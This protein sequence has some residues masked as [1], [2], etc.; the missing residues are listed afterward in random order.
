MRTGHDDQVADSDSQKPT[1]QVGREPRPWT[2]VWG[3]IL[4]LV[5]V[6][7]IVCALVV[8]NRR[9]SG[10]SPFEQL[11]FSVLTLALSTGG[12]VLMAEHYARRQGIREYQQLAKPALRRV[13]EL[14]GGIDVIKEYLR[15]RRGVLAT[16]QG[17]AL[18][19]VQEWLDGALALLELHVG[20]LR[21]SVADWQELL[22]SE[23]QRV[24]SLM[25]AKA[26][27]EAQLASLQAQLAARTA[28]LAAP[29]EKDVNAELRTRA[30][31]AA[32]QELIAGLK[33]EQTNLTYDAY[34]PVA[35]VYTRKSWRPT[36]VSQIVAR[37]HN[38]APSVV[39]A[40]LAQMDFKSMSQMD[41]LIAQL[42]NTPASE[43]DALIA[44]LN[45]KPARD[46]PND[47]QA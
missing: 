26:Q 10:L 16:E 31:I 38:P 8:S 25:E 19:V 40:V 7:V 4:V 12:S 44:Q 33:V 47:G 37:L 42:N 43:I 22:P 36:D 13:L 18:E 20:Q 46:T 28:N 11:L 24:Q 45:H 23:Y 9:E 21:A 35:K 30:E 6:S 3:L 27:L 5:G 15:D 2:A 14:Q 41:A 39:A 32:L 1:E 29:E 17:P 34:D